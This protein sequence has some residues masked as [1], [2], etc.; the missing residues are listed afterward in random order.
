MAIRASG[1]PLLQRRQLLLRAT[2]DWCHCCYRCRNPI[3]RIRDHAHFLR[4]P[5][6]S[7][8]KKIQWL[9]DHALHCCREGCSNFIAAHL[10]STIVVLTLQTWNGYIDL[11]TNCK[12]RLNFATTWETRHKR[13]VIHINYYNVQPLPFFK[14][15]LFILILTI[16]LHQSSS[17]TVRVLVVNK[18]QLIILTEFE[19]TKMCYNWARDKLDDVFDKLVC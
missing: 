14:H 3:G 11:V 6:P 1:P 5:C 7:F 17:I 8:S 16:F 18:F 4:S 13:L 9:L 15:T 2:R 12:C 10:T 19:I